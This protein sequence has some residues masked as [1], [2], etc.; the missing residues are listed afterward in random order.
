MSAGT[1]YAC[2][3]KFGGM[4]VPDAKRL[5]ALEVCD[6]SENDPEHRFPGT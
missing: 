5:T 6:G 3:S 1:F 4:T 2:K